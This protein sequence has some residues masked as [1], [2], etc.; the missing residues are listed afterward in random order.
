MPYGAAQRSCPASSAEQHRGKE[1][2]KA[3]DGQ[4]YT[5]AQ[6]HTHY[7]ISLGEARWES[8]LACGCKSAS[9]YGRNLGYANLENSVQSPGD[10]ANSIQARRVHE[11]KLC[12]Q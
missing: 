10:V 4:L 2:R 11:W 8:A 3:G 7:G 9:D 1:Y 5:R 6:L 12:G